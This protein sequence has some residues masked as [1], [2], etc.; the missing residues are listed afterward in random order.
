MCRRLPEIIVAA[1]TSE[2][3]NS[4][5]SA[6]S[7][8]PIFDGA[9]QI[10]AVSRTA[11]TLDVFATSDDGH[12]MAASWTRQG[13]W[14]EDWLR[15][16]VQPVLT[17]TRQVTAASRTADTLDVFVIGDD[18][19]VCAASW[20]QSA[21]WSPDGF[22]P[23]GPEV[24]DGAH[25]RVAAVQREPESLD[26]YVI[27]G[28]GQVVTTR[29]TQDNGWAGSWSQPLGNAVFD[30]AH[31]QL[32]VVPRATGELDLFAI[33]NDGLVWT[34]FDPSTDDWFPLPGSMAFDAARQRVAAVSTGPNRL[35]LFVI[36][37]DH[38]VWSI[39]RNAKGWDADW[40]RVSAKPGQELF[41]SAQQQVTAISREP[42]ELDLFVIGTDSRAW[43]SPGEVN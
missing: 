11:D 18:G 34:T 42:G 43:F 41:D 7:G 22:Q 19:Q 28:T 10:A 33:G 29:W 32:A 12:V 38:Q 17:T 26:L 23:T 1:M 20:D 39:F 31:Q 9:Q 8:Q 25:Q 36:G 2:T 15:L 14:S 37:S 35:D 27:G 4:V 5:W 40:Y 13:G 30:A 16:P 24:F 6:L 3:W 21:G